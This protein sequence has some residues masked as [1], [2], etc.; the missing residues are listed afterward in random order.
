MQRNQRG[1]SLVELVVAVTVIL[2]LTAIAIPNI[3]QTMESYRLETSASA[4]VGKLMDARINAIKRNRPAWLA[5]NLA[6]GSSQ[7]QIANPAPPPPAANLGTLELLPRGLVF[8]NPPTPAQITFDSLG[9]IVAPQTVRLQVV[10]SGQQKTITVSP[11]GKV[12]VN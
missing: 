11:T 10:R 3:N 4:I 1:F 2:I 9:R 7:V 6:A 8:V 12:T 5:I